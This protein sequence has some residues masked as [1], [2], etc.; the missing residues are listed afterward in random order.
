MDHPSYEVM[1][2][3][4]LRN[5]QRMVWSS[6][7]MSDEAVPLLAARKRKQDHPSSSRSSGRG[8]SSVFRSSC[9]RIIPTTMSSCVVLLSGK[10]YGAKIVYGAKM[11]KMTIRPLVLDHQHFP[12]QHSSFVK[13]SDPSHSP[14]IISSFM[15]SHHQ[16]GIGI[17]KRK[18][19]QAVSSSS[20]ELRLLRPYKVRT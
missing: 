18:L 15:E 1:E 17:S 6:I 5:S 9:I 12:C 7:P 16:K 19:S 10:I 8:Y 14:D 3:S 13:I 4:L 20:I 2:L 11:T